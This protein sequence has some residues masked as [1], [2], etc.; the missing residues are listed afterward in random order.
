MAEREGFEPSYGFL[1]NTISSRALSAAQTSLHILVKSF[2][3]ILLKI[4]IFQPELSFIIIGKH[5]KLSNNI[6]R[7]IKKSSL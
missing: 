3:N 1:H 2:Y 7:I 5:N 4:A 6:Q